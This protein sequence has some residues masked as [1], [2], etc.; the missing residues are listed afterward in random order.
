MIHA[1]RFDDL[2]PAE[3]YAILRLRSEVFVVEQACPYLD[4]DGRDTETETLHLWIGTPAD[5]YLR[6][7]D[8]GY[9][10]RIGRVATRPAARSG[11]LSARLIEHVLATTD[12]PWVLDA[13]SH[14]T[15]WYAR[16]GFAGTGEEFLEDGI[17]HTRMSR[18]A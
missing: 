15:G 6:V 10:R 4:P 2:T 17:P 16:F 11:G 13:Q 3:L 5:A 8:E 12:G 9:S 14:L 18:P 1:R 7:L